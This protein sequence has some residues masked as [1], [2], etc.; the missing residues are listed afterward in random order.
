[1]GLPDR[2]KKKNSWISLDLPFGVATIHP[3][4]VDA[5]LT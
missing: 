3:T 1:M 4:L 5:R 2:S